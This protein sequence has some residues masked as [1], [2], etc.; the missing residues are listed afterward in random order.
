[1]Y[2]AGL[3][4]DRAA[5]GFRLGKYKEYSIDKI[6]QLD[7]FFED[8]VNAPIDM[9]VVLKM[10]RKVGSEIMVNSLA[11]NVK[12]RLKGSKAP[13]DELEDILLKGLKDG[14]PQYSNLSKTVLSR[15][16]LSGFLGPSCRFRTKEKFK[17]RIVNFS[18]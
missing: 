12:P 7:S 6:S 18:R 11:E 4:V 3:Y 17:I 9:T 15:A 16:S 8:M 13:L 10:A 2:A 1:M 5:L 14:L